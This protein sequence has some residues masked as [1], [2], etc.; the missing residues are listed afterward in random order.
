MGRPLILPAPGFL[1]TAKQ[2]FSHWEKFQHHLVHEHNMVP[3]QIAE[4]AALLRL[5]KL[6]QALTKLKHIKRK[7]ERTQPVLFDVVSLRSLVET[8]G[9]RKFLVPDLEIPNQMHK[10]TPI[11]RLVELDRGLTKV[12]RI[13]SKIQQLDRAIFDVFYLGFHVEKN[14]RERKYRVPDHK[15]ILEQ[16]PESTVMVGLR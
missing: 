8:V 9:K 10:L 13:R 12:E 11:L 3:E 4:L 1:P 14:V 6:H 16:M 15:K 7:T 5:V 2:E